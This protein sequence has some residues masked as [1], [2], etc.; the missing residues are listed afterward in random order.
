LQ[1][2]PTG[3]DAEDSNESF[4]LSNFTIDASGNKDI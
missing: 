2:I 4:D 1:A 3:I